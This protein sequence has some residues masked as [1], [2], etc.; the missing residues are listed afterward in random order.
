MNTIT[1]TIAA[2]P[3]NLM[4]LAQAFGDSIDA[5][6]GAEDVPVTQYQDKLRTPDGS[7]T[8]PGEIK[9]T[10]MQPKDPAAE[11]AVAQSIED[12]QQSSREVTKTEVRQK[13]LELTKAGQTE[14]V[15]EVFGRFGAKKFTQ[16][17]E[18]DYAQVLEALEAVS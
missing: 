1:L 13:A 15:E 5:V 16:L 12:T 17:K 14:K 3:A 4:K 11:E 2:T 8:K 9:P 6:I 7:E 18:S 10:D